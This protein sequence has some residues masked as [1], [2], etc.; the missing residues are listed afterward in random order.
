M[1]N[2]RKEEFPDDARTLA[3]L[4]LSDCAVE[5]RGSFAF[6]L[7]ADSLSRGGVEAQLAIER[8][9]ATELATDSDPTRVADMVGLPQVMV[10]YI[11]CVTTFPTR[12]ADVSSFIEGLPD[13]I[14]LE[15]VR[16]MWSVTAVYSEPIQLPAF[17]YAAVERRS[18]STHTELRELTS[19]LMG[20]RKGRAEKGGRRKG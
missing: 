20:R 14:A 17:L 1:S 13:A 5:R 3:S 16:A 8:E 6:N 10:A 4:A 18:N 19:R 11:K 15:A 7:A 2:P 12:A 9:L